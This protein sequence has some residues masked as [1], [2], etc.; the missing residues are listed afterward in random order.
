MRRTWGTR[1]PKFVN[2][3]FK[4]DGSATPSGGTG[5]VVVVTVNQRVGKKANIWVEKKDQSLTFSPFE[6]NIQ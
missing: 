3:H 1:H 6:T 5:V 4:I 2:A